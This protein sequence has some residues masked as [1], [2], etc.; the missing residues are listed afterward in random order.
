MVRH[1]S[2]FYAGA[3]GTTW[4]GNDRFRLRN[5]AFHD[6]GDVQM[7]L[8]AGYGAASAAASISTPG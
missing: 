1:D 7:D 4:R 6:Q 5:P 3:R 8:Y 2:G